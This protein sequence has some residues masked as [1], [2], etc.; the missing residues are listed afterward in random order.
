MLPAFLFILSILLV[1]LHMQTMPMSEIYWSEA[2]DDTTLTDLFAWWKSSAILGA[3]CLAAVILIAGLLGKKIRLKKSFVYIP[4]LVYALFVLIAL[5]AS[6]YKYFA[7][8]CMNEHYEGTFVL[9]AYMM[10]VVFLMNAA[11]SEHRVKLIVVCALGAACLLGV[12]GLS[13]AKRK[14][15]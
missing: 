12:L 13:G 11:D 14:R 6:N 7:L 8:H 4:I 15:R 10:M 9:L 3:G 5:A 1:R 2:A